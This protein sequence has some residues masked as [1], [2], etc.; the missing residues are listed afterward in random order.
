MRAS[1]R[2]IVSSLMLMIFLMGLGAHGFNSK[3][4]AHALDHD[5]QTFGGLAD[6]DHAPGFNANG[7]PDP[8]P[9][10]ETEHQLLHGAGYV[11]PLLL[12]SSLDGFGALPARVAPMLSRWFA[13]P[14]VDLEPPFRPPRSTSRL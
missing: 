9:L 1:S 13:L 14:L 11:E 2:K 10:S 8:E 3:W 5:C 7:D 4:L 12:S 6:H